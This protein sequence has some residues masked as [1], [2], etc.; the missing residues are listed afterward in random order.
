MPGAM[1]GADGDLEQELA[2][3]EQ[4]RQGSHDAFVQLYRQDAPPAW[5]LGLALTGD[6]DRAADAVAE[7]FRRTLAPLRASAPRSAVPFRLRLLTATRQAALDG[8]TRGA[9]PLTAPN[10]PADDAAPARS[11]SPR[12]AEVMA[13]FGKLPERWRTI[14]WLLVVEGLGTLDA[15]RVLSVR[16]E[17]AEDLADRAQAG[18]R[19]RWTRDQRDT[20]IEHPVAPDHLD[21]QL[22]PV[23][24]LP[25]ELFALAEG[26]WLATRRRDAGPLRLVLP[27]GRPVPRW[28]ERS[29]VGATAALIALGITSALAVDNEGR[30]PGTLAAGAGD[31]RGDE[32]GGG[33][34]DSGTTSTLPVEPKAYLDDGPVG[35]STTRPGRRGVDG[36]STTSVTGLAAVPA[37]PSSAGGEGA[38]AGDDDADPTTTTT[39]APLLEVTL[40]LGS[41]L[42]LSLGDQC[43]GLEL[44]GTVAGCAPDTADDGLTLDV[45]SALLP[46]S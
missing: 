18:L 44:G 17:E 43:T 34:R 26:R 42:G 9:L 30:T 11:R 14:L 41:T 15:A 5:R 19:E 27:G 8:P 31:D 32:S 7:G 6:A 1:T 20:G 38:A 4:A 12:A 24:P 40:G 29:L 25:R 2:A 46:G 13:A 45:D 39:V 35:T 23:L 36:T 16:P 28:A 37:T 22:Q 3:V 10:T 21:R 33:D